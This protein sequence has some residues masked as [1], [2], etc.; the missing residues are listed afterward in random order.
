MWVISYGPTGEWS[1]IL[2]LVPRGRL[3]AWRARASEGR[4]PLVLN[5]VVSG[6]TRKEYTHGDWT[7]VCRLVEIAGEG[8]D[9]DDD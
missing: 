2:C 7:Y 4:V 5:K 9:A 1:S 8:D 6:L 3:A